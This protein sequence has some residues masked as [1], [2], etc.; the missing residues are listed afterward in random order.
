VDGE[1]QAPQSVAVER[2]RSTFR[3]L[4]VALAF[5][6]VASAVGVSIAVARRTH[7]DPAA[8]NADVRATT[9]CPRMTTGSAGSAPRA[10]AEVCTVSRFPT[11]A[12]ED[13]VIDPLGIAVAPDNTLFVL[14]RESTAR[15][16]SV[17]VESTDV[18]RI[19]SDGRLSWTAQ[20]SDRAISRRA[21]RIE[22]VVVGE[23]VLVLWSR[24]M[25]VGPT[26]SGRGTTVVALESFELMLS[27]ISM[28]GQV[29]S[30]RRVT[31]V[32][33]GSQ[34]AMSGAGVA[35]LYGGPS[36]THLEFFGSDG[37]SGWQRDVSGY[38]GADDPGAIAMVDGDA[39]VVTHGSERTAAPAGD[40]ER[41]VRD[42]DL[43][44]FDAHGNL[45]W[46]RN[47]AS[48]GGRVVL[49]TGESVIV[50]GVND[51]DEVGAVAR[52]PARL[53]AWSADGTSLW[54][55]DPGLNSI[56]RIVIGGGGLVV[57]GSRGTFE[58][59]TA[60]I[61][62]YSLKG[63][64]RERITSGES[65]V[66]SYGIVDLK[67]DDGGGLVVLAQRFRGSRQ[68]G[69]GI[70]GGGVDPIAVAFHLTPPAGDGEVGALEHLLAN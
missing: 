48:A 26:T 20:L 5:V 31:T 39:V 28:S 36:G 35:V 63:E 43:H 51:E 66:E 56:G 23:Q 69:K 16:G 44:R 21:P 37:A 17:A 25:P 45:L 29:S 1:T 67:S 65:Y 34:V 53:E 38:V 46:N 7:D 52:G 55:T 14:T 30:S 62:G 2:G 49:G 18:R 42:A 11:A 32:E 13:H 61:T 68:P 59:G 60:F 33:S 6:A 3:L 15:D 58:G 8:A 12:G 19:E 4:A 24:S 22:A 40:E 9:T 54:T 47:I 57:L 10:V 70:Y 27:S 64:R 41:G 50:V